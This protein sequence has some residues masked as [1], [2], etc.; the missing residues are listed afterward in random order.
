MFIWQSYE[1]RTIHTLKYMVL[2]KAEGHGQTSVH[3]W[4]SFWM[5]QK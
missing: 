3:H 1:R 4:T 2:R 5:E